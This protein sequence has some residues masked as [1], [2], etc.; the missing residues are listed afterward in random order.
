MSSSPAASSDGQAMRR[1]IGT[2]GLMFVAV[3]AIVGSGWLLAA[4]PAA[5]MAGPSAIVAWIVGAIM[6]GLIGLVYAELGTM[7]PLSGAVVRFPH[8]THGTLTSYSVGWISWL[9]A[10]S[11]GPVEVEAVLQYSSNYL[12]F[13]TTVKA[14]VPVLSTAGYAIAVAL[15][16]VFSVINIVGVRLF[17]RINTVVVWWKLGVIALVVIAFLVTEFHPD[18]F[19]AYG[20]FAPDGAH[21]IFL[22]V[23][24]GGIAF[25][26]FGFRQGIELA[27][28][29]RNPQRSV[30]WTI[31]GS[32][33]ITVVL[34]VL[35]QVAFL[36]AAPTSSLAK[37]GWTH[38]TFAN[39][40]GPMAGIAEIIGLTWLAAILY[41]DA[42]ISPA[43]SGLV[44][45]TATSRVSYAMARSKTA[46]RVMA[47]VSR[48]GVPWVSVVITFVVGLLIFLP[49]PS[50]QKLAAFLTAANVISFGSGPV[51]LLALR[52]SM[53]DA[54]RPFR[55]PAATLLS[56]LAFYA[57]SLLVYWV[58]W[59]T[60]WK[61][62]VAMAIGFVLYAIHR[63]TQPAPRPTL[64]W[65]Q[66][67]WMVGWLAGL[68]VISRLGSFGGG[69]G[70]I[71]LDVSF[72]LL[73]VFSALVLWWGVATRLPDDQIRSQI[74]EYGHDKADVE[75]SSATPGLVE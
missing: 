17:A 53:P 27:G 43:D 30:P 36:S 64:H 13:L 42:V 14:G 12:S 71:G 1:D 48:R 15:L 10:V 23:A 8:F 65:T 49:F 70:L 25:S 38:L 9:V 4:L 7:F 47:R 16:L 56:F 20:G 18:H 31:I 75:P 39:A 32:L 59:T 46:P 54:K 74:D 73:A 66:F 26:Y 34:Y 72:P 55:L 3:G 62:Y 61:M 37:D 69:T 51:T 6:I 29:A 22:A 11:L 60:D 35:V 63:A 21:G 5:Q 52:R 24:T 44:Y 58:G 68:F 28:E 67:S 41:A 33:A 19:T 50:W 2:L 40:F 45:T 57:T